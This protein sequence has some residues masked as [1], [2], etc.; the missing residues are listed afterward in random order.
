MAL[1][2]GENLHTVEEF[3]HAISAGVDFPQPDASNIGGISGWLKVAALAEA[4]ELP[5][6]SH[7]MHELHVSL[8]SAVPNGGWLEIHSFPIDAFTT[9]GALRVVDGYCEPPDVPGVGVE[10]DWA[11]LAPH[12]VPTAA[13]RL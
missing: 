10:F 2:Q 8:V 7:G 9:R 11:K 1:A 6:S 4:H 5:V 13:A 12:R 3:V